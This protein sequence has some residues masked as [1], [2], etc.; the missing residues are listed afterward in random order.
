MK[1]SGK[2]TSGAGESTG[3]TTEQANSYLSRFGLITRHMT[4]SGMNF[5]DI[6]YY[7]EFRYIMLYLLEGLTL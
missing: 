7:Y 3:E 6:E 5:T 2:V 4:S 1:W